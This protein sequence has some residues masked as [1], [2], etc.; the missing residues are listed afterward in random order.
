[1]KKFQGVCRKQTVPAYKY[2]AMGSIIAIALMASSANAQDTVA[3]PA[4]TA[5]GQAAQREQTTIVVTARKREESILEAPVSVQAFSNEALEDAGL[6]ELES[7]AEFTPNLDFQN[8]GNSQPGRF[9]TGIRFRGMDSTISTPTNQT[10]ALLV[11]GISVLGGGSSIDF[12]D[13]GS[14]EVIRGPQPV[15]FGRGTFGGAINYI[16]ADPSDTFGGKITASYSPNYGSTYLSGY[17]EGA[18]TDGLTARLT[19]FLRKKGAMYTANDGG[20]MGEEKTQGLSAIVLYEPDD[21]IRIK[22]CLSYTEDD[23]GAPSTTYLSFRD[24]GNVASGTTLDVMTTT[25]MQTGVFA[26]TYYSGVLPQTGTISSNT[27]FYNVREGTANEVSVRDAFLNL[28][29]QYD[30][31][32]SLDH[33]GLR[34][35]LTIASLSA[36]FA[37]SDAVTLST[38]FGY[39]RKSTAQIRDTDLTDVEAW[40]ATTFLDLETYSAEAR[41]S[42]DNDGPLRVT[43]GVNYATASQFGDIDGGFSVIDGIFGGLQVGYG[44]GS[45]DNVDIK[46]LGIFGSVEY[47]I[48]D[49]LTFAAEARQQ[50]DDSTPST[51]NIG[52][53]NVIVEQDK[54]SYNEFLP[55]VILSAEPIDGTHLYLSYSEGTLP[56]TRNGVF[57]ALTAQDRT[58]AQAQFPFVVENIDSEKLTTYELGWKQEFPAAN[59]WWS[60]VAFTQDWSNMKSTGSF[61]FTSPTS[62]TSY[63]LFSTLA[64]DSRMRGIEFE[65]NWKATD[66][67]RF[68]ATYGYVDAKYLDFVNQSFD[69]ILGI[70][71]D[72]AYKADGNS[73][74]RSPKHSGSATAVLSNP[75]S[76]DWS[77]QLRGDVVYRGRAYTDELN[78]TQI[79]SYAVVNGRLAFQRWADN[80]EVE[81]FCTNCFDK[82]GWAT[83]RRLTDFGLIPNFFSAQGVV[84]NP[85][86]RFEAGVRVSYEF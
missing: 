26:P 34:S 9:N 73:L 82:K 76:D 69:G 40:A 62:G 23:D 71:S 48:L 7:V 63:N 8:L 78:L 50:F 27:R 24:I 44:T 70:S 53:G 32:P 20:S 25:G 2:G 18:I 77:Y 11:D 45:L 60:L 15:F 84:L 51:G 74:P 86:D 28:A 13:I 37:F 30:G 16:T 66:S 52:T 43:G 65:A 33:F 12:S 29:P 54:M 85:I 1:M 4:V 47:D 75:I 19:G 55:R 56:G 21:R 10:G 79:G 58:D 83:G 59:I 42:Y 14:I 38:L 72:A 80:L 46:T 64:G 22:G 49:W 6:L 68:Q 41:L 57:D 31:V 3:D 17:I 81:L 36:D 67:L 35:N 61:V 39:N 5:T